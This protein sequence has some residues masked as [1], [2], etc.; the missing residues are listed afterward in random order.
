[1]HSIKRGY[2]IVLALQFHVRRPHP[3]DA[4]ER[5][6]LGAHTPARRLH[7]DH[8]RLRDRRHRPAAAPG[9]IV[10]V[11]IACV[12]GALAGPVVYSYLTWKRE[13]KQ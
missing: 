6:G 10:A 5:A 8:H 9:L 1:M 4:V 13:M 12:V 2:P 3:M 11:F 7:H